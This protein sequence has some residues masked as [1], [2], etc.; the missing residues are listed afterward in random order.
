MKIAYFVWEYPPRL[1]G[2]LG[3]Y[4]SEITKKFDEMGHEL[5]VFTMNE[6]H[7]LLTNEDVSKNIRVHRPIVAEASNVFPVFV[8][9]ELRRWGT[10]FK[11]FS[12]VL[13]YNVL[14]A[15]KYVNDTA[16][17]WKADLVVA[18]D[19]LSAMAG[20]IAKQNTKL[21][22]VQHFH[23]TEYGRSGGGGSSTVRGLEYEAAQQADMIAT[24]SYAMREELNFLK[25]PAAKTRVI[26]N[27][28]DEKKC[29]I[30]KF[31]KQKRDEYRAKIGVDEKDK[32]ILFTGRLTWV[33]GIDTL[34]RAMPAI[35][36]KA[37]KTKLVVL[38]RGEML[39]ELKAVA[40]QLNIVKNIIFIDKWVD[41]KERLILYAS[42]DIVCAPSRYEPFG[43]VSLEGMSMKKP[44]IV[45]YGGL[46]EAVIEGQHGLYCDPN[47]PQNLAEQAIK[48]L[49]NDDLA[50]KYGE[51]GRKRVEEYFTWDKIAA[52]TIALYET[53]L[54]RQ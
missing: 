40:A 9:E 38:G 7:S 51:N 41:E 48:L 5:E 32:M 43:I 13:S 8:D 26:W 36:E 15:N 23:S 50:R 31:A 20:C 19:W 11:F 14:A 2:G 12:D 34:V 49:T 10:G 22:Y 25:F 1:V 47:S 52:D 35:L 16:R 46:R 33:K 29:D 45:G 39:D 28:V 21:P 53:L 54:E 37:P 18:H 30:S 4:A 6:N 3:T 24:V 42:A 27:G 44:V 17:T